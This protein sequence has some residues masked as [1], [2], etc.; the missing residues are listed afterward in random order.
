MARPATASWSAAL[1]ERAEQLFPGGVDSAVRAEI[2]ATLDAA[3]MA[4]TA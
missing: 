2:E 4:F 1:V 3:R